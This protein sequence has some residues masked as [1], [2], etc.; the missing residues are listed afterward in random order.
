MVTDMTNGRTFSVLL[1]FSLPMLLSVAFQQLY[2]IVDSVIA[3]NFVSDMALGAIGASYPVTMIFM[4]VATGGSV[5]ASVVV[6]RLFGSK[7]YTYMKTAINTALVSFAA[8]A[9]VLTVIGCALCSPM[10]TLLGTPDDIFADSVVLLINKVD[11]VKDKSE[12]LSLIKEYSELYDFKEIIPISVRQRIGVEEIMPVIDRYVKL[13]PH[14]FDDELPTDQAEKVWLAEIVREKILRNMNE[15]IP[16][17][18]AVYVETMEVRQKPN[19]KEIVDIGIVI[20]CEKASHKGMIIG[21]QGSML[22]KIGSEAR[23]DMQDY[24][25]CKV[26]MQIWVKVKEDWRNRESD[27]ADFG[28]KAD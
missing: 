20:V 17:G 13:S 2:N 8:I 18:T 27:I 24:F 7:N 16:H 22:K 25:G 6:A 1:K 11:L 21:K 4:A 12:L 19:G 14:Y 23:E 5:G 3:G 9:G 15:E 10:L 28:L 26:N